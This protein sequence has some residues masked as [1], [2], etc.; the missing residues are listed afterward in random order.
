MREEAPLQPL[1]GHRRRESA[2]FTAVESH[3]VRSKKEEA[4]LAEMAATLKGSPHAVYN[5]M[6]RLGFKRVLPG[7]NGICGD[8]FAEEQ[9]AAAIGNG[10]FA[11]DAKTI[12]TGG[13]PA[14]PE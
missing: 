3:L 14:R 10:S 5:R 2:V 1:C 6:R 12:T 7:E 11:W 9:F 8:G 4:V 13:R